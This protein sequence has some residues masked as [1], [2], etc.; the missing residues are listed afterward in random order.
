MV[1]ITVVFDISIARQVLGFFYYTF[2][3]GFVI[4][5]IL[6]LNEL[7]IV[8]VI[9]FSIG[10]SVA[11]LMIAGLLINEF[12][13]L[14]GVSKPLSL[15]PL[16]IFLNSLILMGGFIF[17]LK[18]EDVEF[19]NSGPLKKSLVILLFLQ[20]PIL[21]IIGA[22]YV[23]AYQNNL[24]LLFM[25]I[26]I[27]LLFIVSI[28]FKKLLPSKLWPFAVLMI[29]TAI[30]CHSS[31]IS[32]YILPFGSDVPIE[33]CVFK[34]TQN[35]AYWNSTPPSFWDIRYGRINTMLSVT[36]LPTLYSTL[37]K[38]D[39]TWT[40]KLIFPII[41]AF[42]PLGLYQIWQ[43]H[44][45]KKYAFIS[46]FLFMAQETF[47]TE[48]LGLNRQMIAELFFVL[49]LLV[50]LN[51]K[52]K[53]V[54]KMI[55]F[56]IFSFCLVTSHYS[57]AEI[58]LFFIS[59]ALTVMIILKHP[60]RNIT[61]SMVIFFFAVMFTWYIYISGAVTFNSFLEYGDY[62]Y[63]QLSDFFNP[64]SRGE[65]VL[66]GLGMV[67]SRSFWNTISR[68]FAYLTEA[69]IVVGFVGSIT[70]RARVR[71]EKECFI[72]GLTAMI[73]LVMLILL[74][75]LANTL[76]MTRFYHVLLYFL[77]PFCGIGAEFI[78]KLLFKRKREFAV[79]ALSVIVLVPYF[80]FQTGFMYEVTGSD[81]WSIPLSGY[82]MNALRLYGLY[83]YT[84]AH[85]VYGAQWLSKNCDTRFSWIYSDYASAGSVLK[86]YGMFYR[87]A[88]LSN[89]TEIM[90]NGTVY[91][92]QL[93]VVN[94]IVMSGFVWNITEFSPVLADMS[95]IYTNGGCEI[96]KNT[97]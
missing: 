84:E 5:K 59:F 29:A 63:R 20:L 24:L 90:L 38:I 30:L 85:S 74:P 61:V 77:A 82:R 17:F 19:R 23:N 13:L 64:A 88:E 35:N 71:I 49:L 40:L 86:I 66:T 79:S 55:C 16:M 10:F 9:L 53:P 32:N 26:A 33:F 21:S 94:G 62:V 73:F 42:V 6:K 7:D 87:M 41:F 25:L 78:V 57:L 4:L 81:S 12:S 76:N 37:L 54:N 39:P 67:E 92:S 2:I 68:I 43:I 31:L 34:T 8:E 18:D 50:I 22:I 52:M 45:G 97:G 91:L 47:Y 15:E 80:L 65:V 11:F 14:S 44:V 46:T 36:I 60:S 48:L 27:S 89:T 75:G 58:F 93:N 70:K 96:Y 28:M 3:P 95:Y 56:I 69:F 83:G 1:Y 72:F 51:K